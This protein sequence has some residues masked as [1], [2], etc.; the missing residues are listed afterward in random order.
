MRR[1]GERQNR[2]DRRFALGRRNLSKQKGQVC[3]TGSSTDAGQ[4][5]IYLRKDGERFLDAAT[6]AR[7]IAERADRSLE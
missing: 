6:K 3:C 1:K 7:R 2:K 5:T 4:Q